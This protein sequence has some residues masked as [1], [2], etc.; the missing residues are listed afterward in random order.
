MT[1]FDWRASPPVS[2][3]VLPVGVCP[4]SAGER[5]LWRTHRQPLGP[6]HPAL[7]PGAVLLHAAALLLL[8]LL[9]LL[10]SQEKPKR[11]PLLPASDQPPELLLH[12]GEA[13]AAAARVSECWLTCRT[14]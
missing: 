9:R 12:S 3:Q 4:R 10:G 14:Q 1:V 5:H 6:A 7:L 8:L 13:A 11:D 2:R